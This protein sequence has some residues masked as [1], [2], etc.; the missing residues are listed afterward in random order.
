MKE[1]SI[2]SV[3]LDERATLVIL[4]LAFSTLGL[5]SI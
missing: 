1:N 2:W 3:E 5:N 4:G